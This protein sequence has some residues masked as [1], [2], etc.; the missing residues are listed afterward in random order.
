MKNFR[1]KKNRKQEGRV[2][3]KKSEIN[4]RLTIVRQVLITASAVSSTLRIKKVPAM[5]SQ[6]MNFYSVSL[7][8]LMHGA[9]IS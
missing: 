2:G 9:E 8:F 6:M 1:Q 4:V 5:N 7:Q 3:K